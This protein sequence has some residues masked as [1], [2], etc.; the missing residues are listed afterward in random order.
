MSVQT[1]TAPAR[2]EQAARPVPW[3]TVLPFAVVLAYVNGFWVTALRGA[4]GSTERTTAP[5]TSW[6][7]DSTL[8]LPLFVLAVLVAL[9]LAMHWFGPSGH[10]W[11][12]WP[13]PSRCWT[14]R[15]A[16]CPA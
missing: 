11:P 13:S 10:S 9:T 1:I 12:R 16:A 14:S 8:L 5:F 3:S 2:V 4:V 7:R 15:S 6:L